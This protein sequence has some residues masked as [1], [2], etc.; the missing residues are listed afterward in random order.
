MSNKKPMTPTETAA[1]FFALAVVVE[2][3]SANLSTILR[4]HDHTTPAERREV[5]SS[6]IDTLDII[7]ERIIERAHD[8]TA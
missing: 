3:V 8:V 2:R 4:E 6:E 5:L 1:E 7:R